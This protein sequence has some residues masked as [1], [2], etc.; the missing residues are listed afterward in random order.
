M[1]SVNNLINV[2]FETYINV[3]DIIG[4]LDLETFNNSNILLEKKFFNLNIEKEPRT[5]IYCMGD[6]I[7]AT[8]LDDKTIKKRIKENTKKE[9]LINTHCE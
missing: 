1:S 6:Y 8:P 7:I 5:F 2:G 3:S 4:I 9:I